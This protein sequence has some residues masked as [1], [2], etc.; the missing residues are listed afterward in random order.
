MPR[1]SE[2]DST[3]SPLVDS[4]IKLGG[5]LFS[6][7][8]AHEGFELAYNRWY[9]RDHF[10]AGCMIGPY[11]LAGKRFI[12]TADLKQLR[13]PDP[14]EL[15]GTPH[16]GTFLSIY[17]M[18]EGHHQDWIEWAGERRNGLV[19]AGRMFAERE[20][21]HTKFYHYAWDY[22]RDPDGLPPA[23]A[24]DYPCAGLVAVF[25]DQTDGVDP[26]DFQH[27]QQDE[28]LPSICEGSSA[29]LVIAARL[30]PLSADANKGSPVKWDSEND[31]RQLTLWFLDAHPALA[32]DEVIVP[33]VT[34]LAASGQ[35]R[36]IAA[37]P[38]IPTIP[39]TDTYLDLL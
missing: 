26:S 19:N 36:V 30:L 39:G 5:I 7:V 37:L 28:L 8:E 15:I 24:L 32:W 22:K 1:T 6:L 4:P 25:A 10:Y 27:W 21:A 14:S 12:A 9:E 38:F 2:N 31:R 23:N 35:G 13:E 11:I 29:R 3:P 18:L 17:W 16:N 20:H 34:Q 33:Y